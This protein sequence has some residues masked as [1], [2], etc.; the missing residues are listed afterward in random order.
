MTNTAMNMTAANA[1]VPAPV[2][3]ELPTL[4]E[5]DFSSDELAEDMDGMTMSLPRVKIPAGGALQFELPTGDPQSGGGDPV[6]PREQRLLA[7]G[8]RVR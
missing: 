1:A 3:F 6:Q 8:Q 7:R 2:D 5:C 4:A